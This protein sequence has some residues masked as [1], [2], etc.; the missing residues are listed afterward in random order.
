[1]MRAPTGFVLLML[2][3]GL[4][5]AGQRDTPL[6]ERDAPKLVVTLS[7]DKATFAVNELVPV[8]VRISNPGA[9]PI[10]I[11]NHVSLGA[12]VANLEMTL[13][14]ATGRAFPQMRW[15]H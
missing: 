11:A 4:F 12:G 3:A 8:R 2:Q 9:E 7:V 14:D 13:K 10:L 15:I 5:I 6:A 1:M